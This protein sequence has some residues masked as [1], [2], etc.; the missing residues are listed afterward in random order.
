MD[1]AGGSED[2][3]GIAISGNDVRI[4]DLDGSVTAGYT[5]RAF[6][7][8]LI[9]KAFIDLIYGLTMPYN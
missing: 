7:R 1:K 6:P 5:T 3:I 4:L 2:V 8:L 9:S